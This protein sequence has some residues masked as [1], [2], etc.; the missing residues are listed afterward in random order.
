MGRV[1]FLEVYAIGATLMMV[2]FWWRQHDGSAIEQ[3]SEECSSNNT[4]GKVRK[5]VKR[6]SLSLDDSDDSFR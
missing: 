1:G 5:R 4:D 3:Q 2:Y 6:N